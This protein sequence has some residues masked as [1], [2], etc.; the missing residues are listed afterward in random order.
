VKNGAKRNGDS[1]LPCG[2]IACGHPKNTAAIQKYCGRPKNTV[3]VQKIL[4]PSKKYCGRPK[5]TAA[6]LTKL[7][8]HVHM[9]VDGK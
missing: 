8:L 1:E 7:I 3:A 4:R 6:P 9:A 5:N 2:K